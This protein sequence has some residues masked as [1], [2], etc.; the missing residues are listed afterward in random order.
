MCIPYHGWYLKMRDSYIFRLILFCLE[1][2]RTCPAELIRP[3]QDCVVCWLFLETSPLL[4]G[5][6]VTVKLTDFVM[7]LGSKMPVQILPPRLGSWGRASKMPYPFL[8][9]KGRQDG[10]DNYPDSLSCFWQT[11]LWPNNS[12]ATF[13]AHRFWNIRMAVAFCR[14]LAIHTH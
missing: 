2:G 4:P 6:G 12:H 14:G 11:Y 13:P 9:S 1:A 10:Y 5:S 7:C 8:G 3:L